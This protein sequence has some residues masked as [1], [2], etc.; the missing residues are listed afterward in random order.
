MRRHPIL[1]AIP[2]S[3][4]S[5]ALYRDVARSWRGIGLVYLVVVVAILTLVV[6]I[7]MQFGVSRWSQTQGQGFAEQVP[8]I[9]IRNR[10]IEIDRPMP[11]VI[12]DRQTGAELAIVDTT[13]QITSLDGLEARVLLTADRLVYRKSA[14]ETRVI[15]LSAVNNLTISRAVA[16]RW[17]GIITMWTTT[18][19]APFVFGGF[20]GLR[21]FQVLVFA[22]VGLVVVRLVKAP[23]DFS[24]LMRLTAVA[25]TPALVLEPV[26]DV[27]RW[28]PQ[29]WGALWT[30]IALAYVV[31]SVLANRP[32]AEA[33]APVVSEPRPPAEPLA[34]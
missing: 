7:R 5:R 9:V 15:Q 33:P 30:A 28:K 24:A 31:W 10:V 18:V 13:G 4:F 6:M 34:G 1:L 3:F 26:L 20:F 11:Y 14:A 29:F 8:T 21:L 27:A 16:K 12:Q 22:L 25:L 23:L 19:M 17:L 2:L 32:E